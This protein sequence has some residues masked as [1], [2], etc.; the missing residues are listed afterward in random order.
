MPLSLTAELCLFG[1]LVAATLVA[2]AIGAVRLA[3]MV[4][5]HG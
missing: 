1:P 4:H 3:F 2:G 5:R